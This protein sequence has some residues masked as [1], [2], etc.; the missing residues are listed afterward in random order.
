MSLRSLFCVL[1]LIGGMGDAAAQEASP[2]S[3][4]QRRADVMH[5]ALIG[6]WRSR[7]GNRSL[8]IRLADDGHL[9]LDDRAGRWRVT[10]DGQLELKLADAEDRLTAS[11]ANGQL[12]LSG[13][14]L[15]QAMTFTRDP[16]LS[17]FMI[18]WFG[19]EANSYA[20]RGMRLLAIL[21]WIAGAHLLIAVIQVLGRWVIFSQ[22]G[23]LRVAFR[24]RPQRAS[25][26]LSLILNTCKYIV[27]GIGIGFVLNTFDVDYTTYLASL[28]VIGLAIGF[29]SQGLVQD[30]VTGMFI[31]IEGQFHVGD[32]VELSGQIGRVEEMG[33]RMTRL[34]TIL[35]QVV[36]I[37]NRS[38]AT[39][40]RY[41][42][43]LHVEVTFILP[44]EAQITRAR[45]AT[46][47]VLADI[48]QQFP[49]AFLQVDEPRPSSA[50]EGRQVFTIPMSIWP[51]Q[52][53]IL[54]Q[55]LLPRLKSALPADTFGDMAASFDWHFVRP[56]RLSHR[57]S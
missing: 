7:I 33:L 56:A 51:G 19:L 49:A 46:S 23:P 35:G 53:S 10:P 9:V 45:E 50:S 17:E 3:L 24:Q 39:V 25:T 20:Q 36:T 29:G 48:V 47:T 26:L 28:S 8:S 21:V 2:G 14:G 1:L 18:G 54:D 16:A 15:P 31:I 5:E 11:F 22:W 42:D 55:H 41:G 12:S 57:P 44:S 34:R 40:V 30:M 32:I 4:A 38:I 27:Y 52:Q 6:I 37:P 43:G 13:G